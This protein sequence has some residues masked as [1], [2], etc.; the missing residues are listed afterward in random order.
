MISTCAALNTL[1]YMCSFC[2]LKKNDTHVFVLSR[3][4]NPGRWDILTKTLYIKKKPG[5]RISNVY[6]C[7]ERCKEFLEI[8]AGN[9]EIFWSD[10]QNHLVGTKAIFVE[11]KKLWMRTKTLV[12]GTKK[13]LMTIKNFL[14]ATKTLL[15]EPRNYGRKTKNQF[16][17]KSSN[18]SYCY[19]KNLWK[20]R[21]FG[22]KVKKNVVIRKFLLG[23]KI[24]FFFFVRTKIFR[25]EPRKFLVGIKTS[26][27]GNQN[28][29]GTNQNIFN[30]NQKSLGR[31]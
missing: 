13:F 26:I 8:C 5:D 18:F 4:C 9:Q 16:W 17:R 3:T 11:T 6:L 10:P 19:W 24:S 28:I 31:T 29:Y 22:P 14:M 21:F 20:A 25:W 12:M 23:T 7:T 1:V 2:R 30:G 15:W 27:G